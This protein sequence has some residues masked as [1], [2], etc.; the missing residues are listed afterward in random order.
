M[1]KLLLI[2]V[3]SLLAVFAFAQVN[4]SE[5]SFT[6]S[7][8]TYTEITGGTVLGNTSSDD[9]R[10][11]DPAVPLGGTTNTFGPGFPIGFDFTFGGVVYDR[12]GVSANGLIFL[13]QSSLGTSAVYVYNSYVPLSV[14]YSISG[15]QNL[16]A[17]IAAFTR[18]LQAQTGAELMILSTGSAPDREMVVQWKGYKKYG[19]T[20][21]GDNYN[22]QIRLQEN[23]NKVAFVYGTMTNNATAATPQIG[24]RSQPSGTASNWKNISSTTDWVNPPAGG[25]NTATMTLSSTVYPASGTT[26]TWAPPVAGTEPNPAVV[27]SPADDATMVLR[28]ATLNWASGGG[29]PDGFKLYFGTDGGGTVAP[30]NIVNGTDLLTAMTYD[31][32]PDLAYN[33]T[34]Y[35]Q[36]VPYNT[37]GDARD[38]PIWSFTTAPDPTITSYP[39]Y[40]NFDSVTTPNL[41]YGWSKVINS[42]SS[43]TI[44][45]STTT[46]V[47]SPNLIYMYNSGDTATN[48]VIVLASPP[49]GQAINTLRTKFYARGGTG[50]TL[51]VG[52]LNNLTS[53][54]TFTVYQ[55]IN[56]TASNTLYSVDFSGYTGTD[57]YIGFG[58]GGG[59]TY[60]ST[61]LDDIIFEEPAAIPPLAATNTYPANGLTSLMNPILK[62]TPSITGEPATGYKVYLNDTG[63]FTEGDVVYNGTATSFQTSGNNYG[64]T[65]FWKV[66]PYNTNGDAT[67]VSTWSF[68]TPTETQLAEGFEAVS[69]PP[70][71]WANGASGNF[72]RSTTTPYEGLASAY[73][74]TS[75]STAYVLSTPMLTIDA[76]STLEFYAHT[77]TSNNY[78]T[79]QIATSPDRVTWTP[80]GDPIVLA[81]NGPWQ[82]YSVPLGSAA[83]N[84][85]V[86]F[87]TPAVTTAGSVYIDHVI[88]PDITPVVPGPAT[89]SSPADAAVNQSVRPTLSWTAPTTG[90]VPTGYK[91]YCDTNNPPT[92][93]LT[94]VTAS[95]YTF[96]SN[97]TW[98]QTYYWMIV[99]NNAA[100]DATGNAVR[101]FTVM[102]DPTVYV[103]PE[104]PYS[105]NFD[106]MGTTFPPTDWSRLD[107]LYGGTYT[108]G[109][110]WAQDDW[111]NVT[112]PTNK[113]AKINIYGTTRYGWLITPPVNIPATG[114]ELKFDMGLVDWNGTVAPGAGEQADDRLLVVMS[115]SPTMSN[116]TILREW[117]NTGSPYVFDAIPAAGANYTIELTG[118]TGTKYFAFY[119]ESTVAGGDNDLM[120]DNVLLRQI[121][122]GAPHNVTLVSPANQIDTI[123]PNNVSLSWS[124]AITGGTPTGYTILVGEYPIDPANS[125]YGDYEYETTGTT[126]DLSA[127]DI[128]LG[129]NATWYWAVWAFNGEPRQY[130]DE[131]DPSFMVREFTTIPDPRILSLPYT[132]NFDTVT[133]PALPVDWTAYTYSAT[134]P[135]SVYVKTT[136]TTPNTSP[137]SVGFYNSGDTAANLML[138]TPQVLVDINTIKMTFWARWSSYSSTLEVGTV[139]DPANPASFTLFQSIPL[140]STLAQYTV[141]WSAYAGA[142]QYI[143]FKSVTPSTYSYIYF[144]SMNLSELVDDDLMATAITGL[145]YGFVGT[146][147]T[148]SVTVVNNGTQTANA[149]TVHLKKYGD[150]RL[151]SIAVNTPLA[152]GA[153]AVHDITWT[154]T[155]VTSFEIQGEVEYTGDMVPANNFTPTNLGFGVYPEGALVEGFE[156]G[157]MPE[158]WTVRSAD[159]GI[160]NWEVL[161]SLPRTG[162][163]SARVRW[164]SSTLQNDDWLITPP[165][166][167]SSSITDQI[168]FWMAR[169]STSWP[170]TYEV[171][172]STTDNEI[173][174]FTEILESSDLSAAP[175]NTYIQKTFNLDTYGDAVVYIAIRYTSLD[176]YYLHV[177]DFV[178]PPIYQVAS[179]DA[180]VVSI[181]TSDADVVLS[182]TAVPNATHY[183]V[184]ASDDPY[185][186]FT[187]LGTTANLSYTITAPAATAKFY[188]VTSTNEA[189]AAAKRRAPSAEEQR[190]LDAQEALLKQ[191]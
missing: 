17:R 110:Q 128:V 156:A 174:S 102:A 184:Y 179:L 171:R 99:P 60:R 71:G 51:R 81:S 154:P 92:T 34:Y 147:V 19:T 139:S 180:P 74:Y 44:T 87:Q 39:H 35:W 168:S 118:I 160:Y 159:G 98:E 89:L 7:T 120:V 176:D 13:G 64:R 15:S 164:E 106:G 158:G 9:H 69:F 181:E 131:F 107:G 93:L 105:M 119:G 144:D 143:A 141:N 77:T 117:N 114:Y 5:Y 108:S 100:G 173:A 18:D 136:T 145:P 56:I 33:T 21:T 42:T 177:D 142:D 45:T 111:L 32:N 80:I 116:P 12:I 70:A 157:V 104:A 65:Y 25:V 58:H 130:A 41:P 82:Y 150:E 186:G 170:E 155:S 123:N 103:T 129:Y 66:V 90:G 124:A 135:T 37:F 167:L 182:W 11:V 151:A 97:L 134:S 16:S 8:G 109:S 47:S 148:H 132:Q 3:L 76:G 10:F 43:P 163:Y 22:F 78:Q 153:S 183:K 189:P 59:G 63:S 79:I 83:G 49:M 149:Y 57:T 127:T 115:D 30:T 146:P 14:T 85:Y 166:Q 175:I 187:L 6:A 31:P 113:A 48:P 23:G 4:M 26:Y 46:P 73:K 140:T 137:N 161:A 86:G 72:T 53:S 52:T 36:V 162:T 95:P 152:P 61:Y 55:T 190:R 185:T 94:T 96:T 191:Q 27:S 188:Q 40:E 101:S 91:V 88:G 178:G 29:L 122:A 84:N 38:C 169:T 50:Y 172:L 121:P 112:T 2:A 133:V 126:F 68:N 54:A 125:Y 75:T 24:L 1:K 67:G 62:W 165:L 138:I 28:D 20:G